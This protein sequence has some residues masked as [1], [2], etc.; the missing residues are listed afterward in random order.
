MLV[1][2][3]D[4]LRD[5]VRLAN[6]SDDSAVQQD[7]HAIEDLFTT[8][9]SRPDSCVFQPSRLRTLD[10]SVVILPLGSR[11]LVMRRRAG[12][13]STLLDAL[14][15]KGRWRGARLRFRPWEVQS[16]RGGG[17]VETEEEID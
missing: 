9:L 11:M 15:D 5:L 16:R 17:G 4:H 6:L 8:L 12:D 7:V 14:C 10:E 1:L 2:A 3:L 13:D